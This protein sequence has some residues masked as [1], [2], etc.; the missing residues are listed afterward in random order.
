VFKKVDHIYFQQHM[1]NISR[2]LKEMNDPDCMWQ[3]F[4]TKFKGCIEKFVPTQILKPK[5]KN[6]PEWFCKKAGKL[7]SKQRKTYSNYKHTGDPFYLSKYKLERRY[8]KNE[9]RIMKKDFL[10]NQ[11][12][13]SLARGNSKP[14]FK[15]LKKINN[16]NPPLVS[17]L[18][19]EDPKECAE[20]LNNFFQEQYYKGHQISNIRPLNSTGEDIEISDDGIAKLITNL[21]NEKLAGLDRIRKPDLL[22]DLPNTATCLGHIFRASLAHGRLPNQWKT[23]NVAPIYKGDVSC[24]KSTSLPKRKT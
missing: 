19:T 23:A 11:I 1:E 17:N 21:K 5:N 22:I 18:C 2:E 16:Q 8:T 13:G 6:L 7:T 4:T 24:A 14:F 10:V 3:H 9:V 15:H 12:C 20:P